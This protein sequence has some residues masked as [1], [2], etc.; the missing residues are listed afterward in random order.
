MSVTL[1]L[2]YDLI[3]SVRI[4]HALMETGITV[5]IPKAHA[6]KFSYLANMG[7]S[8]R[9]TVD[10]GSK[11]LDMEVSHA[12]PYIRIGGYL[13][14][15]FLYPKEIIARSNG[16]WGNRD[17]EY[18]FRAYPTADRLQA[19]AEWMRHTGLTPSVH[20]RYFERISGASKFWDEE[21]YT[22]IGKS[23]FSVIP[24]GLD[25]EL[26]EH[27]GGD[28]Y[29]WT[30]RFID[31]VLCGAIPIVQ[32]HTALYEQFEYYLMSDKTYEYDPGIPGRNFKKALELFTM[33][34]NTGKLLYVQ[35]S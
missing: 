13:D 10:Q 26:A 32:G 14:Q 18:L 7:F 5:D 12:K 23:K 24:N 29:Q 17:Q 6:H 8:V 11:W 15:L 20:M 28:N 22:D 9:Y 2:N 30:Y 31:A 16:L 21:Y 25:G 1:P 19:A 34:E 35:N 3:Q 33:S 4:A 27:K